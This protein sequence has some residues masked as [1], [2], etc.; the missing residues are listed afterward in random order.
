V[1]Y[2]EDLADRVRTVLPV[3]EPVTERQMFGGLAFMLGGRMSCGIVKDALMARL[4]PRT[5]VQGRPQAPVT[6]RK[7]CGRQPGRERSGTPRGVRG[8]GQALL[9]LHLARDGA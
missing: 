8:P 7:A 1:A 2:D 4:C 5:A 6:S 9:R 3:G